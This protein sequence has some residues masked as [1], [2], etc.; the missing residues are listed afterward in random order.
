[1]RGITAALLG[2][3]LLALPITFAHAQVTVQPGGT[4]IAPAPAPSASPSTVVTPGPG[5]TTVIAPPGSTITVQPPA[6]T[7]VAVPVQPWCNGAYSTA[8]GSNFGSCPSYVV[9]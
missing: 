3:G 8:G 2:L 5:G 1:M 6:R 7:T 9:R 4:V